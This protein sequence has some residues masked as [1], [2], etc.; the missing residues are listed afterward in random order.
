MCGRYSQTQ[1]ADELARRFRLD[2]V[3]APVRRRYNAAPS[4]EMPVVVL[5]D[6]KR[7]LRAFRWGLVPS[8]AKDH[9]PGPINARAETLAV[10]PMF[11]N[12]L[13][14]RRCL[15]LSDS[16]YEWERIDRSRAKQPYRFVLKDGGL[17]AFAGLWDLWKGPDGSELRTF[18]IVTTTPNEVV[19]PIHDR[20]PVILKEEDE[21]RWC[22]SPGQEAA[23][24]SPILAPYPGM[25]EAYPVSTKVNSPAF[26]SKACVER[27]PQAIPQRS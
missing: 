26:D 5:E 19:R 22:G 24:F 4:Q 11:R 23:P 8:W 15:V 13:K 9:S 6:G 7:V 10:K 21:E 16:F 14:S 1:E 3:E 18:T 20:M 12:L 2:Q 25:M 17:F 27:L